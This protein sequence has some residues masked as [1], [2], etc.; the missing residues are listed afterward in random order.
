MQGQVVWD[1][2]V[3][4]VAFWV[5]HPCRRHPEEREA[6]CVRMNDMYY[7]LPSY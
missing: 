2:G 3:A 1:P 5:P 6:T 4:L 7:L